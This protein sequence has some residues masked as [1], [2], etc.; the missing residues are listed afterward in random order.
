MKQNLPGIIAIGYKR[1]STLPADAVY[2]ALSGLLPN[3][4]QS[5]TEVDFIGVPTAEVEE[6]Y[7]N[8]ASSEKVTLKFQSS[9]DIPTTGI[10]FI[11]KTVENEKFLIG[12]FEKSAVVKR[13]RSTGT[14]SGDAAVSSYTV[15]FEEKKALIPCVA[16]I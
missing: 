1:Q 14:P 3:I 4:L 15:T 5:P 9:N 11:V 6:S 16:V 10:G 7:D 13:E 8:R 2:R 12:T